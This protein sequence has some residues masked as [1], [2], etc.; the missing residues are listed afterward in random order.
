MFGDLKLLNMAS[1]LARHAANR[2]QVLAS[3][4]ANAD[5]AGYKAKDIEPFAEAFLRSQ[6]SHV[7]LA[8][9]TAGSNGDSWRIVYSDASGASPNGNSVSLE[10]QMI[11]TAEAQQSHAA[12]TAIYKKSIEILRMTL[13]RN[14]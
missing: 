8:T 3:N 13:G 12:A 10:D 1:A 11:R 6:S 5:T 14:A 9:S 2:H 4:I 7:R